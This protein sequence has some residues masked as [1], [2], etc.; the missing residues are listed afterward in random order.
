MIKVNENSLLVQENYKNCQIKYTIST[1]QQ[2]KN[3]C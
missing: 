3:F 2:D 1:N